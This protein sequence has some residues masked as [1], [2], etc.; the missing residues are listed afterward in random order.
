VDAAKRNRSKHSQAVYSKKAKSSNPTKETPKGV[1]N[2]NVLLHPLPIETDLRMTSLQ[3]AK[4]CDKQHKHVLRDIDELLEEFQGPDLGREISDC[5]F[6]KNSYKSRGKEH[7]QYELNEIAVILLVSG[8]NIRLRMQI[9]KEWQLYRTAFHNS[10]WTHHDKE[11]QKRVMSTIRATLGDK[12]EKLSYIKAN[13]IVNKAIS[14]SY[15][16]EKMVKKADM[17]KPML[18]ARQEALE[19]FEKLFSVKPD[20]TWCKEAIYSIYKNKKILN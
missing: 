17:S 13:T 9:I 5:V 8:Y 10:Q 1:Q 2:M 14:N 4:L 7:R 16:F 3:I 11:I 19:K 18:D 15:G 6:D 12:T 20:Y